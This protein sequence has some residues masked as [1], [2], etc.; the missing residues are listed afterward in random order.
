[1]RKLAV[2]ASFCAFLFLTQFA[3]AQQIDA[4]IGGGTL[5]S[6]GTCNDLTGLCPEKGGLYINLGGDAVFYKQLGVNVETAWRATQG[7][8]A[9]LGE[10]YRPILTDFNLLYQPH[11][12]K[13]VGLD[14]MAGIGSA[15]TRFYEP[16][17]SCSGCVN[18]VS[19]DHFMEHLGGG[20]R[21]YPW[22][23]VFIRPEVHYY[24]IQ[25]NNNLNNNGYFSTNNVIRVGASIGYTFGGHD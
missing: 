23:H 9:N 15:D 25:N 21:F 7:T 19:T 17:A 20:V 10:N 4:F 5:T 14:L 24:H 18:Y 12:A 2:L 13:K 11:I 22:H 16:G 1:M 6:S 8:Y 3:S